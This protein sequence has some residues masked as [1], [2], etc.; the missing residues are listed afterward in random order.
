MDINVCITLGS[1]DLIPGL[2]WG[3]AVAADDCRVCYDCAEGAGAGVCC[4][5]LQYVAVCYSVLE[6]VAVCCSVLQRCRVL[7]GVNECCS[8]GA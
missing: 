4:S 6:C 7:Q 2:W 3:R 5:V 8:V 1:R